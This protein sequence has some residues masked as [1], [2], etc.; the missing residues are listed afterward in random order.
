MSNNDFNHV[1]REELF[2]SIESRLDNISLMCTE[3]RQILEENYP[4]LFVP[5]EET[6]TAMR[7]KQRIICFL[8]KLNIIKMLFKK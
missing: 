7:F 8:L 2:K 1:R 4:I 3:I 5:L 6:D